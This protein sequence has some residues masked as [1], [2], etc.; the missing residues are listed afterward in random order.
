M[1]KILLTASLLLSLTALAQTPIQAFYSASLIPEDDNI[2]HYVMVTPASPIDQSDTG[3][4]SAMAWNFNNLSVVTTTATSVVAPTNDDI[5]N[6]PGTTLVVETNTQGGN[7]TYYYL[8]DGQQ[9]TNIT[10]AETSQMTLKYTTGGLIGN[11]PMSLNEQYMGGVTGTF[12]GNG[13]EG[14]FTG[15]ALSTVDAYGTLTVNQG[16]EGPKNVTRLKIEQNLTLNYMGFPVGTLQQTIYSYYSADLV[17]GP[18]LR[19]IT[20]HIVVTPAGI[21][22][23]QST[24][25]IYDQATN[26]LNDNSNLLAEVVIA[27]NPVKDVLHIAADFDIE[28]MTITDAL[29]RTVLQGKGNDVSVSHLPAGIYHVAINS[30]KGSTSLKM[31][32]Q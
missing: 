20:T 30:L 4:G 1:K 21:D 29:G 8:A 23:T 25:E 5:A 24:M 31:V 22:E 26:G 15:T 32:K 27:P 12:Q 17:A 18:V 13:V 7:P 9:G 6:F 16:F 2:T 11:F 14:T 3:N 19:S 28:K 10:G